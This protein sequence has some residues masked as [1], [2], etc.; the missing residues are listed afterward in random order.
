VLW[1]CEH[2]SYV[3]PASLPS[4]SLF[5][6]TQVLFITCTSPKSMGRDSSV[7]V[8]TRCELDGPEIEYQ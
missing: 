1:F 8:A 5:F 6:I 2:L 4:V 3:S 7:G